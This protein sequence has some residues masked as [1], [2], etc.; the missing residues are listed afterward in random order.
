MFFFKF[1]DNAQKTKFRRIENIEKK[2]RSTELHQEFN[3]IYIKE[4]LC[5]DG[6]DFNAI[7]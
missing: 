3:E 7:V 2:L 1:L 4:N 6:M 5:Y